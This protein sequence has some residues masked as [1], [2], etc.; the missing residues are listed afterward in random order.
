MNRSS[1]ISKPSDIHD[2]FKFFRENLEFF[3]LP[4]I[5]AFLHSFR[6]F[7]TI[8]IYM[9]MGL[10]SLRD[11]FVNEQTLQDAMKY[12]AYWISS[13]CQGGDNYVLTEDSHIEKTIPAIGL[14]YDYTKIHDFVVATQKEWA[15]LHFNEKQKTISFRYSD[16][17]KSSL[18][19]TRLGDRLKKQALA[20][21]ELGNGLDKIKGL[22]KALSR[23]LKTITFSKDGKLR[24]NTDAFI[25]NRMKEFSKTTLEKEYILPHSWSVGAYS[26]K[27]FRN[28]WLHLNKFIWIHSFAL[29]MAIINDLNDNLGYINNSIVIINKNT[30][31]NYFKKHTGLT[32][33]V[34]NEII[35]DLIYDV[36]IPFMDVMYQPLIELNK[37]NILLVPT[38]IINSFVDRNFQVLLTKLPHRRTEYDKLKN[39]K[40][41]KMIHDISGYLIDGGF[42]F[43]PKTKLKDNNHV[44]TDLD[45]IIWDQ[46]CLN[47]LIVQLKWFY[48][49]DSTQEL[50]NQD[51]QFEEGI[52]KTI[53]SIEHVKNNFAQLESL[54]GVPSSKTPKKVFGTIV[55]K[56]GTP[57]PYVKDPNFPVIEEDNF[58]EFVKMAD[59]NV[60]N[61]Y[62]SICQFFKSKKEA[63]DIKV[64]SA[65]IEVRDYTFVLPAFEY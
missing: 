6:I 12:M 56:L 57:S 9:E 14:T 52:D 17:A 37:N 45:I 28:L 31:I 55:S 61:L 27:D 20:T 30:L 2:L 18:F 49:A 22:E 21:T 1:E 36:Q 16:P 11:L 4:R 39:L 13:E 3:K 41:D 33:D 10:T 48:G 46:F 54:L 32:K 53:K 50:Y 58:I 29:R 8:H 44:I 38:L 62:K 23:L 19:F 40:E 24:Y 5:E 47:F 42:S 35:G 26:I 34:V 7:E 43:R 60:E 25:L 59:G 15:T 65:E 51:C 63:P 64:S